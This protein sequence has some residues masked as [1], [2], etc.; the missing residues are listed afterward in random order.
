MSGCG[1][2]DSEMPRHHP[3]DDAAIEAFLTGQLADEDLAP[4]AGLVEDLDSMT[5]GPAPVPS[6]QL[7]AMLT[8]G[9]STENGDLLVT[10]ASNVTGPAPQ[11]AG[12]PKWRKKKMVVVELLAGLS[13]A[14][15]AAFG[16]SAAAAA[17]TAGG[18]AGVLPAPAQH[19]VATGVEAVTPFS[20]PDEADDKADFGGTVSTDARDGGVD[21]PTVSAE[22][23]LNGDVNRPADTPDGTDPDAGR[24]A[25]PGQTGLDRANQTPAAGHAPTAVPTGR[26]ADAGT[27]STA[28]RGTASSTPAAGRAPTA[29]PAGPPSS[30]PPAGAGTQSSAGLGAAS[31]TPAA[32]FIP[33]SVPPA[34]PGR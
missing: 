18:A 12:L 29:V 28:G 10:A 4:L 14:A 13:L 24:P 11:A 15:K 32:G 23:K 34:R 7:A 20:F 8:D 5:S 25:A 30:T 19:V 22:A 33:S 1:D 6:M 31:S 2:D 16:M 27:Q 21:G 9:F 26:P 17:V 3:L